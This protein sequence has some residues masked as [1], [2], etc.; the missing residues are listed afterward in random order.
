LNA[1]SRFAVVGDPIAHTLSPAMHRAALAAAGLDATYEAIR[2]PPADLAPCIRLLRERGYAGFNVTIPHKEAIRPYLNTI[3]SEAEKV[4]A[5]NTV[6]R[7]NGALVGY[8]TDVPGFLAALGTLGVRM[9]GEGALVLGAGGAARSIGHALA[10]AG[11]RVI[12][13]NR[14][15][16]KA[17]RL[18]RTLDTEARALEADDP[19]IQ[20]AMRE[21]ALVVNCTPLGME[22]MRD[23]C[24]LPDG[25]H[26]DS[27]VA[28]MDLIYG[29][30][31]PLLALA[32]A[33][34]C[35]AMDGL[36]ML[37]QQGAESFRLWTGLEPDITAM[38]A[39]CYAQLRSVAPCSVS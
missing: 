34:G 23:A 26:F 33:A 13:V 3:S 30:E 29:R 12:V 25:V 32:H 16:E 11:A 31:T 14:N 5:V 17:E 38:R 6:V 20:D 10:S 2:V 36:E 18:A 39:A 9:A 1:P 35:R 24:P 28:V 21:A 22:H 27:D 15:W 37:V 4:G 19:A 8:N 7:A